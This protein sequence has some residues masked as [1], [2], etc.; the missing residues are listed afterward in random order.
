MNLK[1]KKNLLKKMFKWA[2]KKCKNLKI[3]NFVFF[4]QKK[5]K[6]KEKKWRYHYFTLM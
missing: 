3:Y 6:T 5:K 1:K 2:N 4:K